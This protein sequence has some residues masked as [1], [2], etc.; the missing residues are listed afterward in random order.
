MPFAPMLAPM[1]HLSRQMM[2]HYPHIRMAAKREAVEVLNITSKLRGN[3]KE[4]PKVRPKPAV[5]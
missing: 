5:Q 3:F 4:S 1:G 2:E